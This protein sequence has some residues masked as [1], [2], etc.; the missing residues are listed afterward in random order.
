[1]QSISRDL[2]CYVFTQGQHSGSG[3]AVRR[4]WEET[5]V[6]HGQSG[7]ALDSSLDVRGLS[8]IEPSSRMV[9]GV[10]TISTVEQVGRRLSSL[11]CCNA[12]CIFSLDPFGREAVVAEQHLSHPAEA[13]SELLKVLGCGVVEALG[14]SVFH[15]G[16]RFPPWACDIDTSSIR[17]VH[18]L[19]ECRDEGVGAV[20]GG[21]GGK[22]GLIQ[23]GQCQVESPEVDSIVQLY[24]YIWEPFVLEWDTGPAAGP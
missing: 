20:G 9:D 10:L 5:V 6:T 23:A 14:P 13:P 16:R 3:V 21:R 15:L 19:N 12:G 18:D 7:Q 2:L 11:V 17:R 1:M 4:E 22:I 24:F 8:Q